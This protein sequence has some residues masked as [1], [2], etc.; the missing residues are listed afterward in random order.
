MSGVARILKIRIQFKIV[1]NNK[2][3]KYIE[4][5]TNNKVISISEVGGGCIARNF[6]VTTKEESYFLKKHNCSDS[7]VKEFNGLN[8]L[9]QHGLKTPRPLFYNERFL[10]LEYINPAPKKAYFFEKLGKD[11][12]KLHKV[13]SSDFGFFEDNYIGLNLQINSKKSSW[14]DFYI[15]NRMEFQ[16]DLCKRNGYLDIVELYKKVRRKIF[17]ILKKEKEIPSLIHGDLWSG[18]V[19][20]NNNGEPVFIDPAPYYANREMELAM[21]YLFGGF[22]EDFYESYNDNY[23][24]KKNW[25]DR[26]NIYKLYHILNHLNM[27]GECYKHQALSLMRYYI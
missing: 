3:K 2:I 10:V 6:K 15:S 12:A 17:L 27:F 4:F 18:N 11:L 25:H 14:A 5:K 1:D 24:L 20:C 21:T 9:R 23:P 8:Y 19:M 22:T 16:I 26:V 13:T 7:I